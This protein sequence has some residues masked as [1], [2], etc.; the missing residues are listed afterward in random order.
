MRLLNIREGFACNSSSTHSIIYSKADRV[1]YAVG[2]SEFGWQPF[3]AASDEA[4]QA[5][6]SATVLREL[7][8]RGFAPEMAELIA[9]SLLP[10]APNNK[11][12]VD[13][14]SALSLPSP[15][16]GLGIDM[17]FVQ[18]LAEWLLDPHLVILGGNDND[19]YS[20]E[21][22]EGERHLDFYEAMPIE[23]QDSNALIARKDSRGYWTLFNRVHGEKRRITFERA[24]RDLAF[25][26]GKADAPEL[27]DLKITDFCPYGCATCYQGSTQQGA[28]ADKNTLYGLL[29]SLGEMRVFEVALGGGEPTLH[30]D[31][32]SILK[33][34]RMYGVIPNITTRDP[35]WFLRFPE[36]LD[37]VGA[38][39]VSCDDSFQI[40]SVLKHI[41]KLPHDLQRTARDK[42][43]VQHI[44]GLKPA[45]EVKYL[46][47]DCA[48]ES[49]AITLLGY[50][51]TGRGE[52]F[53]PH[54]PHKGGTWGEW[55]TNFYNDD[56]ALKPWRIG[57]DTVLA[58]ELEGHVPDHRI[59]KMEGE[60]S[61]YIDA[62]TP[63]PA[64]YASSFGDG[65]MV[66]L[67]DAYSGAE[68]RKAWKA[69][70]PYAPKS[71]YAY[72]PGRQAYQ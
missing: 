62:T 5:W 56:Q 64:M 45:H 42:M 23:Q 54:V 32:L 30:P 12:Y 67:S 8:Q 37:L 60:F 29:H 31:F 43:V 69:I 44:L 58:G 57:V 34:A 28:H 50:K 17:G 26:K 24:G 20:P 51:V 41:D 70:M 71:S 63:K 25:R 19:D 1:D 22:L 3:V 6:L 61:C 13:H 11:S 65:K 72:K 59:T 16:K 35:G 55:L 48:R 53:K 40:G 10:I 33:T 27:V 2:K 46:L 9:G 4:K 49:I 52:T 47:G 7:Y 18:E 15:W 66:E 38:Y 21:L 68:L 14:Q 39:A 36:A